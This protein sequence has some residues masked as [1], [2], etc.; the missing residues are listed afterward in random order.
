MFDFIKECGLNGWPAVAAIAI[1]CIAI[2]SFF[3]GWP[4]LITHNH[5]HKDDEDGE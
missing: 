3:H 2:V 1:V 4:T 5:Y